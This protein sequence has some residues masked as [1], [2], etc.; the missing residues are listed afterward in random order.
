L[1]GTDKLAA[2]R[3]AGLGVTA[4]LLPLIAQEHTKTKVAALATLSLSKP[5]AYLLASTAAAHT[6]LA[7]RSAGR[8]QLVLDSNTSLEAVRNQAIGR[9]A[10]E[11]D[12]IVRDDGAMPPHTVS[13]REEI[14]AAGAYSCEY[15]T[16]RLSC[17]FELSLS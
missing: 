17:R 16:A 2:Q 13:R 8:T 7:F 14:A 5:E 10:N 1:G 11:I 12:Q 4:A 15:C 9:L 6:M 3:D